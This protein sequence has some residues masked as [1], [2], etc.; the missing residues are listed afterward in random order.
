M[1]DD[2]EF[3]A[4][5]SVSVINRKGVLDA[6]KIHVR[7]S[8]EWIPIGQ[9][10]TEMAKN[11]GVMYERSPE[12]IQYFWNKRNGHSIEF[13]KLPAEIRRMIR[14]YAIAPEGE[15]HPLSEFVK[16]RRYIAAPELARKDARIFMG[17]G[18]DG[19][20]DKLKLMRGEYSEYVRHRTQEVHPKISLP[21]TNLLLVNK[22]IHQEALEAGWNGTVK[23][24]TDSENFI[25]V[26]DSKVGAAKHF[27][28]LGRI[29]LSFTTGEWLRFS[30][31]KTDLGLSLRQTKD[32]SF[33]PY[34]AQLAKTA[35]LSIRFR[36]PD[37]GWAD[38]PWGQAVQTTA[39]QSVMIDWIMIFAF[40]HIKH[41]AFIN[42]TGCIKK[43]QKQKWESLLERE[44]ARVAHD[45]DQAAAVKSI[46]GIGVNDL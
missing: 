27:N 1:E 39:C 5:V 24:F 8:G 6:N 3:P 28:V 30:G 26:V 36:D 34:L 11:S 44:R 12:S 38:H 23:C 25:A 35:R 22:W 20:L 2:E 43:L 16:H 29:E 9:W 33:G 21:N 13:K 7:I 37:D 32:E 45:F 19:G 31:I 18:H 41:I 46:L 42:L 14:Q 40:S 10:L 17:I 4:T 15:I